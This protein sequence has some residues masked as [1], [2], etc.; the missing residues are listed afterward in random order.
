M[1]AFNVSRRSF[2]RKVAATG[3]G[4]ALGFTIPLA[5][6]RAGGGA[7]P[8]ITAW[9]VIEPDDTVIIRVARSEMGQGSSTA[10][11]MLVAEELEC[12]WAKVRHEFA[13]PHENL[14]RRRVWGDM[15]TGGSRSGRNSQDMLRKA[16]APARKM[17]IGAAAPQWTVPASE[18]RAENSLITP[19]A[20]GRSLR[21][22]KIAEAAA[23]IKPPA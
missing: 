7:A 18:C 23:K 2:L 11:P 3:G 5:P 19:L 4:L 20:S 16:G 13:A 15:S 6:A 14:R 22:G 1:V 10:L 21:Y 17:L 8:E 9:I 12:D